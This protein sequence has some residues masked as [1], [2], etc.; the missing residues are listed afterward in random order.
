M[1]R[2]GTRLLSSF[3]LMV[4]F[5]LGGIWV[6]MQI[7][8]EKQES[9]NDVSYDK[10]NEPG[11]RDYDSYVSDFTLVK[12]SDVDTLL[13]EKESFVLYVGRG[14]CPYCQ[15]FAP[16][17]NKAYQ[18]TG[19]EIYYLDSENSDSNPELTKFRESFSID[20]VPF[21]M[22]F[23]GENNYTILDFSAED[24]SVEVL[25]DFIAEDN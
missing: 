17:L 14:S 6:G 5:F 21:L 3:I 8:E 13:K 10:Q 11:E 12:M 18:D 7:T 20:Y 24:V 22:R 23:D 9:E 16:K 2:D 25:S 15:I 1:N 19:V 4:I